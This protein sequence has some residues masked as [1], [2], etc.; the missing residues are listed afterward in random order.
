MKLSRF[1]SA[2]ALASAALA[3]PQVAAAQDTGDEAETTASTDND[4]VVTGSRL[5]RVPG[6]E[7]P[8]PVT[9]VTVEELT[10]SGN[11][12]LGDALNQLPSLRSTYSQANSTRFIGTAGLNLLD[13]RGLGTARSLV[14]VNGRRHI[15]ATPGSY[16]VDVN[17]IPVQLLE[18][19]DVVTGGNSATYGSDAV[20]GVVNFI[21][22]QD[23]EGLEI[24]GQGGISSRGD[25]DSQRLGVTWGTNF[26]DG[27]GNIAIAA[28]Y[29]RSSTL[30]FDD[31]DNQTGAYSGIPGYFTS[32]PVAGEPA[33]G[34][35]IPD[36]TFFSIN[37]PGNRFGIISLGGTV[38]TVCPALTGTGI[39]LAQRAANC[40][41][42]LSPT[43]GRL[44]DSYVFLADGTLTR[45]DPTIDLRSIGGGRFG[46]LT[47]TGVEGAMLLPGLE[48]YAG[49]LLAKY[50]FSP[51]ATA[52]LEAKFVKITNNQ[53]S[54]QPTFVNS[55]LSPT[56]YLDNPYLSAQ[57][58]DALRVIQG[59]APGTAA[60]DSGS[61]SFFRFNND[62]GT[63]AE[64][65]KRETFRIVGGLRGELSDTGNLRYEV[66]ANFGRTDTYYETGGNV[67]V[68]KFNRAADAVR[69]GAGQIVCRVNADAS[70]TN[71]DP[72]CRPLNLFGEG[73]PLTTP[74][75][76]AYVLYTSSRKQWAEQ[77]NFV[78]YIA[79][80]TGGFF[81]LPGG[82]VSMVLGAEYR[83]EDAFSD[84]DDFTQSGATFLNGFATFDP[85]AITVKEA[86][87]ELRI[88]ILSGTPF[89]H[90]LAIEGSGRVSDYSTMSDPVWAYNVAAV[91]AP[92]RDL[93][94]RAGYAK[95]VRAPDLSDVYATPGD[96]F[97]NNLTD[98]CDQ[99][100]T[101][102]NSNNI[103]SRPNRAANC[104][105]AGIPTTIT[106]PDGSVV[107]WYN[108]PS[109]G[110][111]GVSAGN[112]NLQPEIGYSFTVGAVFQPSFV[113]GL[114]ITVDYYD[115]EIKQALN[116]LTGQALIN[117]CYDDPGGINNPFCDAV[118]RRTSANGIVNG[119]FAGQAGRRFDGL[120]DI[121]LLAAPYG[122]T[123]GSGFLS[124]PFNY[125]KL[126]TSGI[127]VDVNYTTRVGEGTL[128]A[129]AIVSWLDEREQFTYITDPARS[130]RINNTLGDPEWQGQLSVNLNFP[131]WDLGY[132]LRYV[133]KQTVY[134]WE[135]QFEHQ[136]RPATNLDI[137]A[138]PYYPAVVYHDMQLG[139][140]VAD[141][142][143]RFYIGV[144][145]LTDELPPLGATGTTAGSAIWPVQGRYFY[146]GFRVKM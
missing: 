129:R 95:S 67:D 69:N 30:L 45:D 12:S 65:H 52:F 108:R 130:D 104:A 38:N 59:Y 118:F 119:T 16:S 105:A 1:L 10:D 113:R 97:A 134:I 143:Y 6:A 64:D 17:T 41:G 78:G 34:D 24:V 21:L 135:T 117:R 26:A 128:T 31:R 63:R 89:F 32:E 75:G 96:T 35:G 123:L 138:D 141:N 19:V 54:T 8:I 127:D 37:S 74:D 146:A 125:A 145:N 42:E 40:T 48:R 136:G 132:D 100:G 103:T 94:F 50:E 110:I 124:A 7:S 79:G 90:E 98:P 28:E 46:G 76:L 58:R 66:A 47:A 72:S 73:A 115:I 131:S 112:P 4:I 22:K 82:P 14:V 57:A 68:A 87:A 18:R 140:K 29:A 83:R 15:T 142:K 111:Q 5:L 43:G 88:P 102:N 2:S 9:S 3:L 144:D 126:T 62:I 121:N 23:Y 11:L 122:Q 91:W 99:P 80:D 84:Y 93:R 56:F 13:L 77:L 36:Q 86:F 85:P 25:R 60:Y 49:N 81:N 61:F 33:S 44:S 39:N 133:G 92:I 109:S 71:D 116:S 20:S 120:P 106:L 114:T 70:T 139:F 27:R 53:T 107:P 101:G 55:R 51:A 137:L